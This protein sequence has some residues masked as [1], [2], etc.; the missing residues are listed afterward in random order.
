VKAHGQIVQVVIA[1]TD[2]TDRKRA[3]D[4]LAKA[5]ELLRLAVVVRDS[6]DAVTVQDLEGRTTAWN[7]GAARMYG[8]SEAEAL[9]LNVRDRIPP[10][11]RKDALAT[12][13]RLARAEVLEPFRTQRI[14]KDSAVVEITMT[15]TALL[16]EAGEMYAIA[17]T[18]RLS[19]P[20]MSEGDGGTP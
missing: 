19:S 14:T 16:N 7:P 8:W 4:A 20:M 10:A 11:L 6:P 13:L 18:E 3:E 17:T 1:F 15:A 12:N 5:A 9:L 2:I